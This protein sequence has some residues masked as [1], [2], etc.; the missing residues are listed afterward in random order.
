MSCNGK[1]R[2]VKIGDFGIAEV[3]ELLGVGAG[4]GNTV[5]YSTFLPTKSTVGMPI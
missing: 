4:V 1:G 2:D 3:R 5:G